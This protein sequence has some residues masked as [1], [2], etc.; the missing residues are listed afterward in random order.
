MRDSQQ[1]IKATVSVN[2]SDI[3][4]KAHEDKEQGKEMEK[5][6]KKRVSGKL[7]VILSVKS[8]TFHFF[9]LIGLFCT[10]HVFSLLLST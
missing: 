9:F 7:L 1:E 3:A 4:A 8:S 5:L 10:F 6:S 2:T